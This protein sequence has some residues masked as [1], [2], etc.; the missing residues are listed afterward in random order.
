[1]QK[2]ISSIQSVTLVFLFCV[3]LNAC[4]ASSTTTVTN[5]ETVETSI[6]TSDPV[7]ESSTDPDTG[8]VTQTSTV[9]TTQTTLGDITT[10]ITVI[11]TTDVTTTI[12]NPT[13]GETTVTTDSDSNTITHTSELDR[14]I[15]TMVETTIVSSVNNFQTQV[16]TLDSQATSFC[17]NTTQANL[18][19][20]Q[21][22]WINAHNAWYQLAPFIFGPLELA[23]AITVPAFWYLDSYRNNGNDYTGTV[24]THLTSLLNSE[25][26]ISEID[27]ANQ[28]YNQ[29]GLLALEVSLFERSTDQSQA[30]ENI[31][32][33]F[34]H[35][36]RKCEIFMAH[37]QELLRHS[38]FIQ[39]GWN[40][41][42]RDTGKSY[43]ELLLSNQLE[44]ALD[45]ESGDSAISKITVAV[46]EFYDYL[47]KRN[48]STDVAQL[49]NSN[50]Q[51]LLAS[52][53]ITETLLS[54]SSESSQSIYALMAIN[55]HEQDAAT[56]STNI[57]TFVEAIKNGT[58][59]EIKSAAAA[60]DGNFKRELPDALNVSLGLNFT[61]GD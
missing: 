24:R 4:G 37:S 46:Q 31:T 54:T 34:S 47:N 3:L 45:N 18:I 56:I 25:E 51:A 57:Q 59:E 49:S 32:N 28:N 13:T 42:Y 48:V 8:I 17:A 52:A 2:A 35:S 12:T 38:T 26:Q 9:I 10:S 58:D 40:V 1:M 6:I 30:L 21:N 5:N 29:V 23:N 61:D 44:A 27:F 33:E 22:Q 11:T 36:P 20:I 53:T 41:N 39:Q 60:L 55:D 15:E 43:G 16:Q 14:A 19:L 50:K 7:V